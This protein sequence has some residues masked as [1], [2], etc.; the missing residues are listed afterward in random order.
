MMIA[1]ALAMAPV[2]AGPPQTAETM[3]VVDTTFRA[4]SPT[5]AT[6][7]VGPPA[8]RQLVEV[9]TIDDALAALADRRL[10]H[11][12]PQLLSWAGPGL[13]GLRDR[14]IADAR[15]V[16]TKGRTAQADTGLASVVRPRLRPT[17]LLADALLAG[18]RFAEAVD[19]MRAA[20]DAE[21]KDSP[22]WS[23]HW[24]SMSQWLA[25][26]EDA[27]GRFDAALGILD[28]AIPPLGKDRVKLNLEASRAAVLLERDRPAE[29]LAAIDAV[30]AAFDA[31]GGG[32]L[33]G[34]ARIKG[35]DRQFAWVRACALHKMGRITEAK[36]AAMPLDP[37][38]EP[39]D[40]RFKIDPTV[41]LRKQLA[42]CSQ[43]VAATAR[44]YA[45]ML[46]A[47]PYAGE[48]LTE[49]QPDAKIP[50][51][52]PA[53]MKQ[54]RRHPDLAPILAERLRPLPEA[55]VPALNGWRSG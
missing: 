17:F 18:G 4:V 1:L 11:A 21:P 10:S 41:K 28:A 34:N 48:A 12:W 54:V 19:L 25:K 55:F 40:K 32:I 2:W 24:A 3:V 22:W 38:V 26:A 14:L 6:I 53:F 51:V 31:P 46:T 35:S 36:A 37:A 9:R 5:H 15:T 49:L 27:Q 52:A 7:L 20:R 16:F 44:V 33:S 50:G 23:I 29:A 43:D 13:E 8:A 30:Q 45:G 39:Q 42:L 47:T